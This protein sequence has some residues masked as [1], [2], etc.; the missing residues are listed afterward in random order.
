MFASCLSASRV[1]TSLNSSIAGL[2]GAFLAGFG[3]LTRSWAQRTGVG[4]CS[5]L[6]APRLERGDEE[7]ERLGEGG[8]RGPPL[9]SDA[10][11]AV[12]LSWRGLG[13]GRRL[14]LA[15][16]ERVCRR[17]CKPV[18]VLAGP[19]VDMAF[20]ECDDHPRSNGRRRHNRTA[21]IAH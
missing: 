18:D 10:D 4:S 7:D 3:T 9:T 14:W 17:S 1:T 16:D 2:V 12:V 11:R 21:G 19:G 8:L 5:W 13:T 15:N 20:D 6:Y